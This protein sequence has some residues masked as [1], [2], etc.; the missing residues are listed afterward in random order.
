M[1]PKK[2]PAA[3]KLAL[4]GIT[5]EQTYSKATPI[6]FLCDE[7]ERVRIRTIWPRPKNRALSA[8][9]KITGLKPRTISTP[10]PSAERL[11]H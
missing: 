9:I 7:G 4:C 2:S 11:L 6:F 1:N 8:R 10:A 5:S 3:F